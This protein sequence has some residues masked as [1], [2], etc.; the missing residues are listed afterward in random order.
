[1]TADVIL[2]ATG[3]WV[4][5]TNAA[6][7]EGG[8][9]EPLVGGTKGSHLI[10]DHPELLRALN[11]HMIYFENV[12]GRVCILFPYLG[13]GAARLDRHPRRAARQGALRGRG[14][15]LHPQVA[16][17]RL[18]R[19]RRSPRSRSSTATAASGPC[20]A[21]TRASPAA[22]RA[23]ISSRGSPARRRPSASSAASG[24]PSAPSASR[25]PIEALAILG[26]PRAR[27]HR[28]T[29]DRRRRSA[30]RPTR[31]GGRR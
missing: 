2:N 13:Q 7:A 27:R 26:M 8:A 25:R 19:H 4:D 30:S 3:A 5:E 31:P 17:L 6:L 15:R 14:G 9:P 23:T 10:L 18:P 16:L 24:R 1:M 21:A 22:S 11:G 28:V 12:D 20:R 29:P